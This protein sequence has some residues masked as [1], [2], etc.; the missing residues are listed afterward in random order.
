MFDCFKIANSCLKENYE[1]FFN[2]I[3][4]ESPSDIYN[5]QKEV[6]ISDCKQMHVES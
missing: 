4:L 6:L 3:K 1:L 2:H 5:Y